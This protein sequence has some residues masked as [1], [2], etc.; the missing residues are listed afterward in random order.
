MEKL[1]RTLP[2]VLSRRVDLSEM[3]S[4]CRRCHNVLQM[5]RNCATPRYTATHRNT[6]QRGVSETQRNCRTLQPTATQ[7]NILQRGVLEMQRNCKTLQ[8]TATHRNTLQRGVP[9][10]QRTAQKHAA[11]RQREG[12]SSWLLRMRTIL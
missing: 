8:P 1:Q 4:I 7:R 2:T 11:K 3:Q 9:E 12:T 6:L 10:M 5:H